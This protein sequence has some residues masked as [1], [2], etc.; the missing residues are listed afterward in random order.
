MGGLLIVLAL[1]IS[2]MLW[3]QWNAQVDLTMLSVLVLAGLGFYDDYIEDF[4]RQIWTHIGPAI[5]ASSRPATEIT[6]PCGAI[7]IKAVAR[8]ESKQA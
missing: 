6:P 4:R 5:P 3:T 1:L 7:S 2:T 8:I